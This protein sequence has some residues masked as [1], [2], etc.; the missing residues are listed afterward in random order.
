MPLYETKRSNDPKRTRLNPQQRAIIWMT[1][2]GKEHFDQRLTSILADWG[3]SPVHKGACLSLPAAWAAIDPMK[4]MEMFDYPK[5]PLKGAD[6]P[7]SFILSSPARTLANYE[8]VYK[9]DDHTT[10]LTRAAAWFENNRWSESPPR[11]VDLDN[12]LGSSRWQNVHGSHLC[13]QDLCLLHLVLES[14]QLNEDRKK[15]YE[16]ARFLRGEGKPIPERCDCEQ[17]VPKCFM[18]LAALTSYESYLRQ[19][20]VLRQ[21]RGLPP[22][23]SPPQRPRRH[24]FRTFE[25]QIPLKFCEGPPPS[26]AAYGILTGLQPYRDKPDLICPFC[27][28]ITGFA[29]VLAIWSHLFHQ[30][31]DKSNN[32]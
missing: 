7:V 24:P 3:V 30:Y 16:R 11:G 14:S 26:V 10:S 18:R 25:Y 29:S 9:L 20:A 15:C 12:F 31:E 32:N 5:C 6:R 19:F 21:A 8:K 2:D 1:S 17:H 28:R 22:I 4:L 27:T 13:H 23:Q